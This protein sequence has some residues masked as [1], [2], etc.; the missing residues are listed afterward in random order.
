MKYRQYHGDKG[1]CH[2]GLSVLGRAA[3]AELAVGFATRGLAGFPGACPS[4]EILHIEAFSG[5]RVL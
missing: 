1:A 2:S 3:T 4:A 5:L